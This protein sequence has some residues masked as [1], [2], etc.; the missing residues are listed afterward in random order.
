MQNLYKIEICH[1]QIGQNQ[2]GK[3]RF[4]TLDVEIFGQNLRKQ[5][6]AIVQGMK[7]A[8][9]GVSPFEL[10]IGTI[11]AFGSRYQPRVLWFGI[12]KSEQ[13]EQIY[14]QIQKE[15]WKIGFKFDFGNF[16]PHITIARINKI[17]DKHRFWNLIESMKVPLI[18]QVKVEK[19]ILY[20]SILDERVPEYKVIEEVIFL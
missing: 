6:P 5:I 10:K 15:M 18:Q 16:V 4:D 7:S 9:A 11:G 3:L 20:E 12:D 14:T 1:Y 2:L 17:D 13:L 8:A 19:I